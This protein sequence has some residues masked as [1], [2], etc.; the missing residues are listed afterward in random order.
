MAQRKSESQLNRERDRLIS[1]LKKLESD[2]VLWE[3]NI[4][5]FAKTKNAEAMIREVQQ[6]ID[7]AKEEIKVLEEKIRIIENMVND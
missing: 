6:K 2:I 4:G 1:R 5:F 3:N 7:S